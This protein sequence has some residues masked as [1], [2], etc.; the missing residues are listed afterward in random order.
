MFYTI[1]R[2]GETLGLYFP[3][4]SKPWPCNSTAALIDSS[5]TLWEFNKKHLRKQLGAVRTGRAWAR[6]RLLGKP[7]S[8]LQGAGQEGPPALSGPG[9]ARVNRGHTAVPCGDRALCGPQW[10]ASISSSIKKGYL[11]V[12]IKWAGE[13]E[14]LL[15]DRRLMEG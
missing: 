12:R 4:P 13:G 7:F 8:K 1:T 6:F 5:I 10:T 15:P 3:P 14:P 9:W 2:P 11:I